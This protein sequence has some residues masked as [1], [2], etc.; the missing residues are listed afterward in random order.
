MSSDF[1]RFPTR[2][3]VKFPAGVHGRKSR[4][5]PI[6]HG[7]NPGTCLSSQ[8]HLQ[9]YFNVTLS[10]DIIIHLRQ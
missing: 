8:Q 10:S 6:L 9:C 5:P 4:K 2:L 3:L 7:E 1:P